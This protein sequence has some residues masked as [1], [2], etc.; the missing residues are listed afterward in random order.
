[1]GESL[2]SIIKTFLNITLE[3]IN[4]LKSE[5]SVKMYEKAINW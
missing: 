1:M 4:S 5:I 3:E 2:D